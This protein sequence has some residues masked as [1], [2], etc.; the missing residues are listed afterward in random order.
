VSTYDAYTRIA[1]GTT[2]AIA[3]V[4]DS[5]R[6]INGVSGTPL[7]LAGRNIGSGTKL[8]FRIFWTQTVD[9]GVA[10]VAFSV[11][12]SDFADLSSPTVL[13]SKT[14]VSSQLVVGREMD[15]EIPSLTEAAAA[16]QTYIGLGWLA[17][18]APSTGAFSAWIPLGHSPN[19]PSR[20]TANYVGPT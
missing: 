12:T 18:A 2:L 19:K 9:V 11:I 16:G 1:N 7:S 8:A 14:F 4:T 20:L 3:G 13:G 6:V 15:I 10:S 17:S 5:I